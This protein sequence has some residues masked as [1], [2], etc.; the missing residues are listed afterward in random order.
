MPLLDK[1]FLGG[2]VQLYRVKPREKIP[3]KRLKFSFLKY[4]SNKSLWVVA[5]NIGDLQAYMYGKCARV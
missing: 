3:G 1:M 4:V 2:G 5:F